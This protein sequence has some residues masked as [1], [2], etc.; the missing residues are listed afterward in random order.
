MEREKVEISK[1]LISEIR[2]R[3]QGTEFKSIS[4][5]IEYVLQVVLTEDDSTEDLRKTED[6]LRALGYIE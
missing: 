1:E 4:D 3:I 5:Y 6:R 2:K